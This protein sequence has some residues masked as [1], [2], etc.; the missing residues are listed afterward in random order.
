V[1]EL[2]SNVVHMSPVTP[3]EKYILD[4]AQEV[5][6]IQSFGRS[7]SKY[8]IEIDDGTLVLVD[9]CRLRPKADTANDRTMSGLRNKVF[10]LLSQ[11]KL[12][13]RKEQMHD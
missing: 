9:V 3:G 2:E 8:C 4:D 12:P 7:L 5:I 13:G 10:S 1:I 6:L 11:W